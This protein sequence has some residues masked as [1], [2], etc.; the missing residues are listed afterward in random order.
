MANLST[1]EALPITDGQTPSPNSQDPTVELAVIKIEANGAAPSRRALD[2]LVA[3]FGQRAGLER[4]EA[5]AGGR[6]LSAPWAE[7]IRVRPGQPIHLI[8]NWRALAPS[9]TSATVFVH[10]LDAG[11]G[12]WAGQD[13]TPL[14]GAFPT[15]LWFP[16]WLEGQRAADPYTIT[17]P[18]DAP[19][20]EYYLEVGLYGLRTIQRWPAFDRL[21]N[22]AGDRFVLGNV[23]VESER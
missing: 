9:E 15:T 16:K 4:V 18:P 19:P 1:G 11:N 22:L 13:Y 2:R 20:G 17:V 3:N 7:P 21:G 5:W 23:T 10:L 14:G 8:L 6:R 12:L